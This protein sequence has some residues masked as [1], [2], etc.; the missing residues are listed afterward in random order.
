MAESYKLVVYSCVTG[1]IDNLAHLLNSQ[2][3]PD[4]RVAWYVFCD[5]VV[6]PTGD[7]DTPVPWKL[8][9][10]SWSHPSVPRRSARFHKVLAHRVLP[11]HEMS[12]W[13]D[14]NL[15]IKPG[16]DM[17]QMAT[18]YL[19]RAD[20]ATFR[21]PQRSCVYQEHQ[22]CLRLRKDDPEV[23]RR[24]MH[25]YRRAGYP[26]NQGMVETS[27]L[28]RRPTILLRGFNEAWWQEIERDSLRDQLSFNYVVH[29]LGLEYAIIP[30]C[31]AQSPYFEFS[32]HARQL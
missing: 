6:A 11:P 30:G 9:P 21:H 18:Q 32:L 1:G 13:I 12:C 28:L 17:V 4:P 14:G 31:R 20:L 16:I 29:C 25:R 24:Q 5:D 8:L 7:L 10:L 22:A 27:C 19:A 3:V 23:M 2:P 15:R 26:A